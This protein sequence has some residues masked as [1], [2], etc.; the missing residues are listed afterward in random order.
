MGRQVYAE[1]SEDEWRM[2]APFQQEHNIC[3]QKVAIGMLQHRYGKFLHGRRFNGT[4]Q[5]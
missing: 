3:K 1:L 5:D 4:S 2:H